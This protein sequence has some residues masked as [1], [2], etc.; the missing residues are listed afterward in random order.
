MFRVSEKPGDDDCQA[1]PFGYATNARYAYTHIISRHG[2]RV[3]VHN[4]VMDTVIQ[5]LDHRFIMNGTLYADLALL[6]PR[7][8]KEIN[9]DGLPDMA[10]QKLSTCLLGFNS[11]ATIENLQ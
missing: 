8:V 7:N 1:L 2:F 4:K 5:S 9:K 6:D 10:L 11:E 3:K